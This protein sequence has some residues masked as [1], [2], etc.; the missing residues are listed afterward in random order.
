MKKNDMK[1]N[2]I[3]YVLLIALMLVIFYM[4]KVMSVKVNNLTFNEFMG[5]VSSGEVTEL[6]VTPNKDGGVYSIEGKLKD[7]KKNETFKVVAPLSEEVVKDLVDGYEK[8]D[9]KI[10][11]Y[12][13]PAASTLLLVLVNV[14]PIV[15]I[16]GVG[17]YLLNRQAGGAAK[18]FDFGKSRAK[19]S[20]SRNKVTFK[21]V[22]GLRKR[23]S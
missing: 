20:D 22:A 7:Y 6:A 21:D 18:S 4:Y 19:L 1:K 3:P 12:K 13:D 8:Y 5:K 14:L 17:F 23:R 2:V 16:V 9:Y 11:V 10:T 15:V